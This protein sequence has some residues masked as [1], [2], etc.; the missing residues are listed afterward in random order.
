MATEPDYGR[1]EGALNIFDGR[2]FRTWRGVLPDQT[3]QSLCP[4]PHGVFLG[5]SIVNGYGTTPTTPVPSSDTSTTAPSGWP[6]LWS[7]PTAA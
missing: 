7:P 6:G 3:V 5:G 4:D 2:R 1:W